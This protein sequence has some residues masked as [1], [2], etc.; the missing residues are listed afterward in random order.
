M[1]VEKGS[2]NS[3][4]ALMEQRNSQLGLR[5]DYMSMECNWKVC[6]FS[7]SLIVVYT[8]RSSECESVSDGIGRSQTVVGKS[9][10]GRN[11]QPTQGEEIIYQLT[12]TGD[13]CLHSYMIGSSLVA[14]FVFLPRCCNFGCGWNDWRQT[15]KQAW[16]RLTAPTIGTYTYTYTHR[17]RREEKRTTLQCFIP[18]Y[19]CW[20]KVSPE[21]GWSPLP[22]T[23]SQ[24]TPPIGLFFPSL[25]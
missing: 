16:V 14:R 5:R 24:P 22:P 20:S 15:S 9:D 23:T 13:V 11:L 18:I 12:P 21:V 19:D 7:L 17:G 2:P 3:S 10:F 8:P 4:I 1:V 25:N 6:C